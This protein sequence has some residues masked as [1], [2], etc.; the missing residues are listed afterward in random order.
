MR[1]ILTAVI[2][3]LFAAS[4]S[5]VNEQWYKF[6]DTTRTAVT[7]VQVGQWVSCT[8]D[9]VEDDCQILSIG[10]ENF[11]VFTAEDLNGDGSGATALTWTFSHCPD[12]QASL[13]TIT[14]QDNACKPYTA[15]NAITGDGQE[16]GLAGV[17]FKV[18]VGGTHANDPQIIVSCVG[19]SGS[20]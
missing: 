19:T 5:G 2:V 16:L 3:L 11:D 20:R 4:A 10:C 14:L 15:L 7:G 12:D 1:Q 8:P 6:G 18:V 17:F 13:G 9:D